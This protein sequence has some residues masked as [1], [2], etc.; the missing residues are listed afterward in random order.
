MNPQYAFNVAG[1]E[2]RRRT[3]IEAVRRL[4]N[5]GSETLSNVRGMTL[6]EVVPLRQFGIRDS[7]IV[8]GPAS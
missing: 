8:K 4:F 3:E 2:I 6:D 7:R 5:Y 1:T